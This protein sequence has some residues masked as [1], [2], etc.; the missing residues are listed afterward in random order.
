MSDI[1]K[2]FGMSRDSLMAI[3][4][5]LGYDY[6]PSGVPAVGQETVV[7]LLD[8]NRGVNLLQRFSEWWSPKFD[9]SKLKPIEYSVYKKAI[10]IADFPNSAVSDLLYFH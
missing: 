6:L 4:L 1:E 9:S 5:L 10:V 8:E 3:A 7:K 2:H